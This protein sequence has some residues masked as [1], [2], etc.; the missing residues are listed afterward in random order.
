[1]HEFDL[2]RG[3]GWRFTMHGP[4]G[5]AYEMNKQFV[6]VLPRECIV[7]RHIQQ[8]HDFLMTMTFAERGGRTEVTWRMRFDDPAEFAKVKAF[9]VTA[10]EENFDR[11]EAHLSANS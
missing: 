8:T 4:D 9:I 5:A 10:N 7:V 11:L 6:E 1:M 3:G 2:R